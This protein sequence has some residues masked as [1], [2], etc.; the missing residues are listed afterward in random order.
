[1]A[2][3]AKH[4]KNLKKSSPE[5]ID[6]WPW[7][8]VTFSMGVLPRLFKKWPWVNLDPFYAKVKFGHIGFCMGK[9]E[10]YLFFG[11]YC[12]LRSQSC[13]KHSA[14]WVNE[15]EYFLTLVRGHSDFK[16]K[17][18]TFGL[19]TQVRDS[20]PHGPLELL[21]R[22]LSMCKCWQITNW[23]KASIICFCLLQS[24]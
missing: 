1:M 10:N 3:M 20:G 2:T 17:W 5:P 13:L 7:N 4:G 14:K 22:I 8:L 18:L 6:W 23:I 15:V 11:N 16:V 9:S 24:K 19:Y 12:S 21:F